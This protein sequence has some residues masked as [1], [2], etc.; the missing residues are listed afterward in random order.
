MGV[1]VI[2]NFTVDALDGNT[3]RLSWTGDAAK[4]AW[5]ALDG[6]WVIKAARHSGTDKQSDIPLPTGTPRALDLVECG[7]SETPTPISFIP[8]LRPEISFDGVTAAA[9]Y[10]VYDTAG[11]NAETE[12]SRLGET[13][14]HRY[15]VRPTRKLDGE[16]GVWH[17]FRVAAFDGYGDSETTETKLLY[18]MDVPPA[19]GTAGATVIEGDVFLYVNNIPS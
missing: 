5:I 11:T 12:I 14:A 8:E 3:S 4:R 13:G 17:R 15:A 2:E 16:N 9:S 19:P 10:R 1:T 6:N 7:T 18:V